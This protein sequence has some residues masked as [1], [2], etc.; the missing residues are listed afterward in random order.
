MKA[1]IN[2]NKFSLVFVVVLLLCGQCCWLYKLLLDS[3]FF[4]ALPIEVAAV[5]TSVG[6]GKVPAVGT[7][8]YVYFFA[9][10][11]IYAAVGSGAV[12]LTVAIGLAYHVITGDSLPDSLMPQP[13]PEPEVINDKSLA[14]LA[15][16]VGFPA[17]IIGTACGDPW[18]SALM[19]GV[20]VA[21]A[22]FM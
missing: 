17:A 12:P 4:S 1:F 6:P 16:F 2:N 19:Y 3:N 18:F 14:Y 7:F 5:F 21:A 10:P 20:I 15:F 13:E 11:L 22:S 8:A 9:L